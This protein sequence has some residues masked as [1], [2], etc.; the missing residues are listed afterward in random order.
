LTRDLTVESNIRKDEI[1]KIFIFSSTGHVISIIDVFFFY[2]H[3]MF[4]LEFGFLLRMGW[5]N[6]QNLVCITSKNEVFVFN[7]N[8]SVLNHFKLPEVCFFLTLEHH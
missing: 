5:T 2:N 6:H 7:V 8:S 4:K 3:K 1:G